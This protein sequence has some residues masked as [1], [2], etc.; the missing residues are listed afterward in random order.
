M[1]DVG[2]IYSC[3]GIKFNTTVAKIMGGAM[4]GWRT[5]TVNRTLHQWISLRSWLCPRPVAA[6]HLDKSRTVDAPTWCCNHKE[7]CSEL[8]D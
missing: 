7:P 6:A 5:K 4:K 3:S 8:N 1:V 2:Q